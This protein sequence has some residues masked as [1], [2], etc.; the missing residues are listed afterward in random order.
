[1]ADIGDAI[2]DQKASVPPRHIHTGTRDRKPQ[3]EQ[4]A[5]RPTS[6]NNEVVEFST[7][8]GC[9]QCLDLRSIQKI[10]ARRPD[11]RAD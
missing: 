11:P 4:A 9:F 2:F 1:M 8:R 5:Q 10:E 3:P 7:L 6:L